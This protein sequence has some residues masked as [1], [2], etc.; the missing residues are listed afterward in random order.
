MNPTTVNFK[1]VEFI[2]AIIVSKTQTEINNLPLNNTSNSTTVSNT[3]STTAIDVNNNTNSTTA[4][5]VNNNTN[6]TTNATLNN[7]L[8]IL[9]I[10]MGSNF[11]NKI[12]FLLNLYTFGYHVV[13]LKSLLNSLISFSI[14]I[15]NMFF[16]PS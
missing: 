3:N 1:N 5:D 8:R 16:N 12:C 14:I 6:S 4:V 15:E 10:N 11:W 7:T 13:I 9:S 2:K